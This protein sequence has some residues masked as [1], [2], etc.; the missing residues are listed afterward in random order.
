[1]VYTIIQSVISKVLFCYAEGGAHSSGPNE[2]RAVPHKS[3]GGSRNN[4]CIT[5]G[6]PFSEHANQRCNPQL[7]LAVLIFDKKRRVFGN[8]RS[9]C[10]FYFSFKEN[11][12]KNNK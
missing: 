11:F 6:H 2:N 8:N 5:I 4:L 12:E 10:I 1:M 7:S 3:T 9:L